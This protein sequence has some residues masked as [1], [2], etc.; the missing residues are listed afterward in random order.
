[1]HDRSDRGEVGWGTPAVRAS[2][3]QW[4]SKKLRFLPGELMWFV[5]AKGKRFAT[6]PGF[7]RS[8]FMDMKY[9]VASLQDPGPIMGY[10]LEAAAALLDPK[11]LKH[12]LRLQRN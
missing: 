10:C 11:Q 5:T 12:R 9:L 2:W 7:F 4:F 6:K 1:M 3:K 8:F